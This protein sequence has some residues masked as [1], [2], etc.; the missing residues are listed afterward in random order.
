M[1]APV[2]RGMG[3]KSSSGLGTSTET[4]AT[5]SSSCLAEVLERGLLERPGLSGALAGADASERSLTVLTIMCEEEPEAEADG[6]VRRSDGGGGDDDDDSGTR[7]KGRAESIMKYKTLEESLRAPK[8][9]LSRR[10]HLAHRQKKV[11]EEKKKKAQM[12][13]KRSSGAAL[14]GMAR[15]A[16]RRVGSLPVMR[17]ALGSVVRL[18]S[19]ANFD[20]GDDSPAGSGSVASSAH[21]APRGGEANAEWASPGPAA[22]AAITTAADAAAIGTSSTTGNGMSKHKEHPKASSGNIFLD[23]LQQQEEKEKGSQEL[24]VQP[25]A[26]HTLLG[27]VTPSLP[28]LSTDPNPTAKESTDNI[29]LDVLK[30]E[31]G[32]QKQVA[33][34]TA[35]AAGAG[36]VF[37]PTTG[38]VF[39]T[40]AQRTS[41]VSRRRASHGDLADLRKSVDLAVAEEAIPRPNKKK[42]LSFKGVTKAFNDSLA[43]LLSNGSKSQGDGIGDEEDESDATV[44]KWSTLEIREYATQ[45]DTNPGVSRGPALALSWSYNVSPRV[46]IEK[47]EELRPPRRKIKEMRMPASEREARL[48]ASG[49]SRKE[50]EASMKSIKEAQK[51]RKKAIDQMKNDT[52]YEMIEAVKRRLLKILGWKKSQKKEEEDLWENAQAYFAV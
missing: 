2:R 27:T 46:M 22:A 21:T 7:T 47:Y 36:L 42:R 14:A 50:I 4:A 45:L 8:Y 49:V 51:K 35:V 17:K 44:L 12:K 16:G 43:S 3:R 23:M 5:E 20:G 34:I 24:Q 9:E 48:L 11:E 19:K 31:E 40:S 13:R 10:K 6:A 1:K 30:Q 37:D 38:L 28:T 52:V 18:A 32:Q 41:R 29:F 15:S 39:K 25:R 33:D 26:G